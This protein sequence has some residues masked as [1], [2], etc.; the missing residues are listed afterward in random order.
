[1]GTG[2]SYQYGKKEIV[3]YLNS[4]LPENAFILDMGAGG[5]TYG[6]YFQDK[7]YNI[8]AVELWQ[9][10]IDQ[11]NRFGWYKNIYQEDIRNFN[12]PRSYDLI[13]FGDV[14]EHLTIEDAQKVLKEAEKHTKAIMVAVPYNYEQGAYYGNEAERHLQPDLTYKLFNER[15]P[16]YK[17][18]VGNEFYGYFYKNLKVK[19]NNMENKICVYAICKN[20][21]KYIEQWLD[22]MSEADYIVVLDTGSTDDTVKKLKADPRVTRVEKKIIKPWRFDVARNES[23]KLVPDDA[24]ILVCTDFDELFVPGWAQPIRDN[25]VDGK[26]NRMY[27]T[28]A[29]SHND[30][31]EPTD[32][33][34]YDKIHTREYHWKFPVHEVLWPDEG[35]TPI[36][37]DLGESVYLHHYQDKSKQRG[38]YFDLLKLAV[39]ENPNDS[40]EQM[41][42]AREYLLNNKI[43]DALREY[44]K[45]LKMPDV[46]VPEKRFVLLESLGRCGDCYRALGN[47]DEAI[48]YYQEWIKEDYTYREPYLGLA[49]VYNNMKMYTLAEAMVETALKYGTRKHTWV[50][51]ADSWVSQP[52]DCL[53]VALYNL[54]DIDKA[55]E[56]TDICLEHHPDDPRL[57][58]N[59]RAMLKAKQLK[60]ENN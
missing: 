26:C 29:W 38:S 28:Y 1:M 51:Q 54:G 49:E 22:N 14:L 58:K 42:F 8:D 4:T 37:Y 59:Y 46:D 50:E 6:Y 34:K 48:W 24:N 21:S 33:F 15:Y 55:I 20:E 53:A 39:E 18:M 52:Q 10:S 2:G 23:M 13:I 31:G 11:L 47:Y 60:E 56:C 17:L 40:H 7:N 44:L 35:V 43:E 12:Y 30:V 19:E 41:L 32:I 16:G 57:L 3:A 5:G 9:E 27:Y 45:V 25:W 36:F